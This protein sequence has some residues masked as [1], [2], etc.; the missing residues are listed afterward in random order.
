MPSLNVKGDSAQ[1]KKQLS[2]ATKIAEQ[3]QR[4][5]ELLQ[6]D[7]KAMLR[8]FKLFDKDNSG[9]LDVLEIKQIVR[10]MGIPD[11][12]RDNYSGFIARN[13]K[14]ADEDMSGEIEFEEF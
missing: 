9:F 11:Y 8:I 1:T 12:E 2:K 6:L 3:A 14:L 10:E 7:E 5:F 4:E 13:A